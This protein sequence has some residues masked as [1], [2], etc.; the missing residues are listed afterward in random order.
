MIEVLLWQRIC[1][2]FLVYI[3]QKADQAGHVYIG[4]NEFIM[5]RSLE[6]HKAHNEYPVHHF[7]A[8]LLN[9]TH[10]HELIL[11]CNPRLK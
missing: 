9:P 2:S 8:Q 1:S 7:N 4:K 11:P 5:V 6:Y 3:S 10:W